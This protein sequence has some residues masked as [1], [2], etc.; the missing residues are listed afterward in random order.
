MSTPKFE[1]KQATRAYQ[2]LCE[3]AN[4]AYKKQKA[5]VDSMK[6]DPFEMLNSLLGIES[7]HFDR[8]EQALVTANK[9]DRDQL[10]HEAQIA[11]EDQH[12]ESLLAIEQRKSEDFDFDA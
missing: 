6:A 11:R 8:M 3:R 2:E 9:I 1:T 5:V 12:L 10:Y 4:Q 7:I